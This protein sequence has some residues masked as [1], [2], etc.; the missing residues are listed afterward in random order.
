MLMLSPTEHCLV[1]GGGFSKY[2]EERAAVNGRQATRQLKNENVIQLFS[3][4]LFLKMSSWINKCLTWSE[5]SFILSSCK[6]QAVQ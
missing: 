5:E 2:K 6:K 3:K 4:I 1:Q